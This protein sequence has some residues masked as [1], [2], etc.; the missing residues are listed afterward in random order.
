MNIENLINKKNKMDGFEL[1]SLIDY[2]S[3][4]T[5]FFDPQY[6]SVLSKLNYGNEGDRQSDRVNLPQ[7]DD[8]TIKNFIFEIEACLKPSGHLFLW[9]D[10]FI[11]VEGVSK[12]T[13][14]TNLEIVDMI[15]W[16]KLTFGMGYRSR[17]VCEYLV[18]LQKLPKRA[19][20]CWDDHSIRDV[21]DEKAL[22]THP[23]A[24]PIELQKRLIEATTNEGDL[25]LDPSAGSYSVLECCEK[26][27]R[28]FIGCD[29]L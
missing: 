9:V 12:L 22:K 4:S 11:L 25:I 16:N 10:K 6:R 8:I 3:I 19:K 21:W 7:M 17:R 20:G 24:K 26:T 2:N 14:L 1:L 23:H 15:T 5:A 28:N 27:S 13:N 29:L 18:V